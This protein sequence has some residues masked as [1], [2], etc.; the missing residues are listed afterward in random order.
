MVKWLG[1]D[2]EADNTW[3]PKRNLTS[4]LVQNYE[5]HAKKRRPSST[6]R[7]LNIEI[8][9]NGS[10]NQS[11]AGQ[12]NVNVV[13]T[14]VTANRNDDFDGNSSDSNNELSFMERGLEPLEIL[15]VSRCSGQIIFLMRF[16][17]IT[18]PDW[19]TAEEARNKCPQV[20]IDFYEKR[21][22]WR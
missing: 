17:G 11:V 13:S 12:S 2:D 14:A 19:V 21:I 4:T 1:F 18:E 3:E 15:G 20:V 6:K 7:S 10:L 22:F 8:N 9:A 16:D 5:K